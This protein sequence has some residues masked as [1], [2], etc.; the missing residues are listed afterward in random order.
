MLITKI[1]RSLNGTFLNIHILCIT[2][3]LNL[4]ERKKKGHNLGD[5]YN[6]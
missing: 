4:T 1:K 2:N 6:S 5:P 3:S